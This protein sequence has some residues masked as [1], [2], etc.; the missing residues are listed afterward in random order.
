[1]L[2]HPFVDW[3]DL[4][5]IDAFRACNQLHTH[6]QDSY[7]D[8]EAESSDLDD[9][10]EEDPTETP[11]RFIHMDLLNSLGH[12]G[13]RLTTIS[14]CTL[15]DMIY[16]LRFGTKSRPKTQLSSLSIQGQAVPKV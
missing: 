5:S 13:N 12:P 14:L 11:G 7:T 8:L 9:E 3:I 6:L 10:S 1:M 15:A 16:P 2:H 4:L